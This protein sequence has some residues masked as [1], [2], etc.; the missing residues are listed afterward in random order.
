L[1]ALPKAPGPPAGDEQRPDSL[2]G[3]ARLEDL[4]PA[5][6]HREVADQQARE[7]TVEVGPAVLRSLVAEPPVQLGHEPETDVLDVPVVHG[8]PRPDPALPNRGGQP[9]WTLDLGQV[10]ALQRRVRAGGHIV[11]DDAEEAPPRQP[12]PGVQRFEQPCRRA[13]PLLADVGE[14]GGRCVVRRRPSGDHHGRRLDPHAPRSEPRVHDLV[15]VADP[16]AAHTGRVVDPAVCRD[17]QVHAVAPQALRHAV[18]G[19]GRGAGQGTRRVDEGGGP[20]TLPP[21]ERSR[22]I[23]VHPL[24][25]ASPLASANHPGDVEVAEPG[26][27]DLP[28]G[29]HALLVAQELAEIHASRLDRRG[30]RPRRSRCCLWIRWSR[31]STME[32][33][34]HLVPEILRGPHLVRPALPPPRRPTLDA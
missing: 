7:V 12:R 25:D 29:E 4:T 19:Q 8:A 17:D 1:P 9:M 32:D 26:L 20:G 13:A 28:A 14:E 27:E 23:D 22:V 5:Q 11:E 34:R 6:T 31:P 21:G 10:P 15:M 18:G 3:A 16:A 30:G 2:G 24:E 33:L